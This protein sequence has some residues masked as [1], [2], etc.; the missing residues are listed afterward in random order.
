MTHAAKADR[1][2][3]YLTPALLF[4]CAAMLA[5]C[6][7][8]LGFLG[9]EKVERQTEVI[10]R[11]GYSLESISNMQKGIINF[12]GQADELAESEL[13]RMIRAELSYRDTVYRHSFRSADGGQAYAVYSKV[14]RRYTEAKVGNLGASTVDGSS[15]SVNIRF[16]SEVLSTEPRDAESLSL[17][18]ADTEF[19]VLGNDTVIREYPY[20]NHGFQAGGVSS[21][22]DRPRFHLVSEPTHEWIESEAVEF[23]EEAALSE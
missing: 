10:P 2:L 15:L 16:T 12:M 19:Q 9:V 8:P 17:A 11:Q 13:E 6:S 21:I 14:Y 22:P 7:D 1:L 23:E 5:G 3:N 20:S 18:Q 4:G